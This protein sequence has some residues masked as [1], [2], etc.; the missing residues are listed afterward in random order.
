M[1]TVPKI[2]R[3]AGYSERSNPTKPSPRARAGVSKT[4]PPSKPSLQA[5]PPRG[6]IRDVPYP[7]F[8]TLGKQLRAIAQSEATSRPD[9]RLVRA[10]TGAGEVDPAAGGFLLQTEFADDL[11]E[12]LY[13]EAVI[14]PLCDRRQVEKPE[15]YVLPAIDETSRADGSRSGGALAYWLAEG[16]AIPQSFPK[17]RRIAFKPNKLIAACQVSSELASDADAL[18]GRLT[19]IFSSE[20]SF[21]LDAAILSGGG[22]GLPQGILNNG[23]LIT[24]AKE[25]GQ[26]SASILPQN[27]LNMWSRMA[28]PCRTRAVW[29]ATEDALSQIDSGATGGFSGIYIP[30][31][32]AGNAAPLLKGRPAIT[33]EQSPALGAVGDIV[34]ADLSQYCL[35]AKPPVNAVSAHVAFLSDQV[36]FRF[37]LRIDGKSKWTTPIAPFNGAATRSPFV[38]LAAR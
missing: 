13:S 14:A 19:D 1:K 8:H 10:P 31:G 2:M 20:I 3:M 22:A 12:S 21:K 9:Y 24:V 26:A 28:A 15:E 37:V 29:L 16:A 7:H 6:E 27:I 34:L 17:F 18:E 33:V 30:S 32:A 11:V 25:T 36:I 4:L 5:P 38:A 35:V 23:S